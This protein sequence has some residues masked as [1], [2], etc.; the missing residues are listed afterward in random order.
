LVEVF[1]SLKYVIIWSG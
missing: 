1:N